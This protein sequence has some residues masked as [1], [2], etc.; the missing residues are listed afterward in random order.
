L[1]EIN[2]TSRALVESALNEPYCRFL[3]VSAAEI[4]SGKVRLKLPY[5]DEVSNPG[6]QVHGGVMSSM[7]GIAGR[8]A[9]LSQTELTAPFSAASAEINVTYLSSAV[10]E[11]MIASGEVMRRGRE[12]THVRCTLATEA[13][14]PLASAMVI[15]RVVPGVESPPPQLTIERGK[16][17][18]AELPSIA[19]ALSGAPFISALG[20]RV[21]RFEG[22]RAELAMAFRADICG[23]DGALH[24]GAL[25]A[26][27]DTA[28]ALS[29]WSTVRP[30]AGMKV[31]T[32]SIDV[33]FS[34]SIK[35]TD[36]VAHS[37]VVTRRNEL[38]FNRV[39]VLTPDGIPIALGNVI[40][41]IVLPE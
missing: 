27:V 2:Q 39:D 7:I 32:V 9:A 19:R 35:D 31:S 28:G 20:I 15:F 26:L 29:A 18:Q 30:K 12:L 21:N 10:G 40:Y 16:P 4:E 23:G 5:R 41:R 24:E 13:D 14:K 1:S 25:G 8:A 17:P 38:F 36:A 22:G 33:N 37:H 11:G 34:A 6:R 3:G